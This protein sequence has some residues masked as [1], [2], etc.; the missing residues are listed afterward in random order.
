MSNQLFKKNVPNDIIIDFIKSIGFKHSNYYILNPDS[1]KKSIF[2]GN[3]DEFLKKIKSYYYDSKQF[4][5]ERKMTYKNLITIIR[6]ILKK[7]NIK[8]ISKIHYQNSDYTIQYYIY[9]E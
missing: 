6:Q 3:T 5:V 4:Y 9:I 1:Y 7:N 2:I 8:Y